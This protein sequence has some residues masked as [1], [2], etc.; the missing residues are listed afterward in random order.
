MEMY[1]RKQM[2]DFPEFEDEIGR[3]RKRELKESYKKC[4]SMHAHKAKYLP[5]NPF[6]EDFYY[7]QGHSKNGVAPQSNKKTQVP[8][9]YKLSSQ[10]AKI[11][12]HPCLEKIF[13]ANRHRRLPPALTNNK[14]A[15][16]VHFGNHAAR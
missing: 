3:K 10:G 9:G 11:D 7:L 8:H 2:L 16:G 1:N 12:H 6:L 5:V 4:L 15:S 14:F 13:P